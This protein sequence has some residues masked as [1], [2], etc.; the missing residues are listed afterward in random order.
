VRE[1]AE[2]CQQKGTGNGSNVTIEALRNVFKTPA[3]ADLTKD[4]SRITR[5]LKHAVFSNDKG[6]TINANNL[7]LFAILNSPGSATHKSEV[8]FSVLQDG[9]FEK[10][11]FL[12]ANDKDI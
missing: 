1:A 7:I 4:D 2:E 11:K 6:K 9:G 10:Q 8:F 12:T 3:W 5:L